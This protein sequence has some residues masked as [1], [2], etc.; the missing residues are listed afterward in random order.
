M[1]SIAK[2]L[3]DQPRVPPNRRRADDEPTA[4]IKAPL[5]Y[6]ARREA[7]R[8]FTA[9]VV[10]WCAGVIGLIASGYMLG[11]LIEAFQKGGF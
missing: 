5:D 9:K 11:E 6:Y 8:A 3:A 4:R 2:T 7:Q 10:T 1:E